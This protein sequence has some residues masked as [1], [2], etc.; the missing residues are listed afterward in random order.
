MLKNIRLY[1]K[2]YKKP[3][4]GLQV[5]EWHNDM[6]Y[7]SGEEAGKEKES[8]SQTILQCPGQETMTV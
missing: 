7:K 2:C 5:G 4:K 1:P 3:L 6:S 8:S